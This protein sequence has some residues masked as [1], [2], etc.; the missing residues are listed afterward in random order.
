M[1]L[2]SSREHARS[3]SLL[4]IA[5][6]A[7]TPSAHAQTNAPSPAAAP[8]AEGTVVLPELSIHGA[9][10]TATGPVRGISAE[11]SAT[12]TKTDTP[13]ILTPQNITVVTRQQMD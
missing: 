12:G 10:E 1:S 4:A 5:L 13:L 11:R 3:V 8:A 7:A 2:A 9:R 6:A